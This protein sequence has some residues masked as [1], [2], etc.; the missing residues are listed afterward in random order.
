M[1]SQLLW[2]PA[3]GEQ[4]GTQAFAGRFT[5]LIVRLVP[6]S[7]TYRDTDLQAIVVFNVRLLKP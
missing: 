4:L 2:R 6:E 3:E 5:R 7:E 1:K